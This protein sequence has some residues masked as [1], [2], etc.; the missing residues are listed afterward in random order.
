MNTLEN[1]ASAVADLSEKLTEIQPNPYQVAVYERRKQLG[2]T[3]QQ[4]A[5]RTGI[6]RPQIANF[7]R[8]RRDLGTTEL[9]LLETAL[10]FKFVPFMNEELA[11]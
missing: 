10:H 8:G 2:L 5:D 11:E 4:L 9:A 1:S 7:E 6:S 3:Q